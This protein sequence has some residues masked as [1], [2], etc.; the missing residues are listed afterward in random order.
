V[1]EVARTVAIRRSGH[2]QT[3]VVINEGPSVDSFHTFSLTLIGRE[4][5]ASSVMQALPVSRGSPPLTG[6]PGPGLTDPIQTVG[7]DA[8]VET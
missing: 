3:P 4:S 2:V 5:L 7:L 6:E 8:S 1:F